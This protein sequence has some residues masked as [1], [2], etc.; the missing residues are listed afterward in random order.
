MRIAFRVRW[1]LAAL[2]AGGGM[3]LGA[4]RWVQGP[5]G[6][7]FLFLAGRFVGWRGFRRGFW[8]RFP[9]ESALRLR[10]SFSG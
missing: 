1:L 8:L 6:C 3:L 4:V 2:P 10:W 5:S 9:P 7:S